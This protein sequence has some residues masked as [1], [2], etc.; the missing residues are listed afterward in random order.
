MENPE[1]RVIISPRAE[2]NKVLNDID[3]FRDEPM[4]FLKTLSTHDSRCSRCSLGEISQ[5]VY[6]I[7]LFVYIHRITLIISFQRC[8]KCKTSMTFPLIKT[9]IKKNISSLNPGRNG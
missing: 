3:N 4:L 8:G 6:P 9:V 1:M 7:S 5:T 2:R